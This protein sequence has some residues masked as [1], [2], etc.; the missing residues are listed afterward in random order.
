MPI[1]PAPFPPARLALGAF[2]PGELLA[3]LETPPDERACQLLEALFPLRH[4]HMHLPD[5]F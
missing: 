3:R 5:R 1:I 4:P 2:P